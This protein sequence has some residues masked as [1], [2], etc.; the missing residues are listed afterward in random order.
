MGNSTY[1][2]RQTACRRWKD[3]WFACALLGY[4][5]EAGVSYHTIA[6]IFGVSRNAICGAVR[7]YVHCVP[8]LRTDRSRRE[9]AIARKTPAR[10]WDEALLTEPY[11]KYKARRHAERHAN[12]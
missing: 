1:G 12:R 11:A 9:A 5:V 2:I 10:G 8:D 3:D 4:A 6:D 7:R